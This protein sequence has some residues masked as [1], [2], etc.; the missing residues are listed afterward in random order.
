MSGALARAAAGTL[1]ASFPGPALPAWLSR[2]VE[3]GLG[4]VCLYGSNRDADVADV[5]ATLHG[6]RPGLVVAVDEEGGDVTRLEAR[7]GSSLAG[8]AALGAVD[9]VTLTREVAGALGR[10]LRAA[11]VDLD[12]APCA[13][14]NSDPG[15]PVIG[16]RAFGAE[17]DLVARHTAAFVAGLQ[18]E[19]V[20]ACA[21]HFPG[22]GAVTVDSH[23][24]LPTVDAPA[25]VVRSRDLAPFRSA[26]SAGVAAI[27]PGH[28]LVPA[29]DT[30]PASVSRRLLVDVLRSELGFMGAVVTD[31]LDMEGIGGR[32]AIPDNVVRALA[33]GADLCCLGSDGDEALVGACVDAV[34]AAVASGALAESRVHDAA[35]RAAALARRSAPAASSVD[36]GGGRLGLGWETLAGLGAEAARR[37]LRVEGH[38]PGPVTGAHVVELDRPENIAAGPVPWGLAAALARLDPSATST[39]VAEGDEAAAAAALTRAHGR[40]LVVVA[41][42][43]ERRPLQATALRTLLS[44]RPDAIVVDMG[45]PTS[46]SPAS[47]AAP[48]APTLAPARV[49]LPEGSHE[50]AT[51]AARLTTF[52]AAPA[53]GTAAARLLL[54]LDAPTTDPGR[55]IRG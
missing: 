45:W 37:A 52:G 42:D 33:A 38:L 16:V 21:K 54:G 46:P 26:I 48:E 5:A 8:N 6:V 23:L 15:N 2:R 44:A 3:G 32:A 7:T 4:G 27:M 29:L 39:R 1:L 19:G 55:T 11:G 53:C 17:A 28:L 50:R 20:A 35:A 24:A 13:D 49:P 9:D 40:Q 25:A 34:V 51:P 12:L 18:A 30:A 31:A 43:A 14:V 22:H 10:V 47:G 36:A 41:R